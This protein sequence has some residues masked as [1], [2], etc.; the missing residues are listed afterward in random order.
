MSS[1]VSTINLLKINGVVTGGDRSSS[2][3][4][5]NPSSYKVTPEDVDYNSER[6]TDATLHRNLIGTKVKIAVTWDKLTASQTER[7]GN[8]IKDAEF[9]LTY[10]DPLSSG[11][12]TVTVYAGNKSFDAKNIF[13]TINA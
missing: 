1:S 6:A 12:K 13:G 3:Y 9:S 4:I 2:S 10:Y 5:P 11:N 8:A 7:I